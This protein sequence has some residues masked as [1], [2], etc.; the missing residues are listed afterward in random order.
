MK[1]FF[2][3]KQTSNCHNVQQDSV[4]TTILH[5]DSSKHLLTAHNLWNCCRGGG[6]VYGYPSFPYY[7][8]HLPR[9]R[10]W[11]LGSDT[12]SIVCMHKTLLPNSFCCILN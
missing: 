9:P 7:M 10:C 6:H 5:S 8:L 3:Q 2:A 11:C 12:R 1:A 4:N